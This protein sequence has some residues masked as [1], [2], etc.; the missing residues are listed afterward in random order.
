MAFCPAAGV[1]EVAPRAGLTATDGGGDIFPPNARRAV[2]WS[3]P[4]LNSALNPSISI[5]SM[6]LL[7][8]RQN[9][10]WPPMLSNVSAYFSSVPSPVELRS[11]E[12]TSEL[13]S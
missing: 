11:E 9:A 12:H 8:T 1:A 6:T 13:Q 2:A 7:G 4:I 3:A 5:T 10:I